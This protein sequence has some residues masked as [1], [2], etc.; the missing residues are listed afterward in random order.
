MV[1]QSLTILLHTYIYWIIH[2]GALTARAAL[3]IL[4][5]N[6]LYISHGQ[7]C[8][9]SSH[10]YTQGSKTQYCPLLPQCPCTACSVTVTSNIYFLNNKISLETL[11]ASNSSKPP[12][13]YRDYRCLQRVL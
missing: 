3:T 4:L 11:W 12:V 8:I 9:C 13:P 7:S 5:Y 10:S 1:A 2:T 6:T